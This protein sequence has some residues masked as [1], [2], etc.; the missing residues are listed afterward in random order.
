MKKLHIPVMSLLAGGAL[1][2]VAQTTPAPQPTICT[3][4]CWGARNGTCTT[5]M[6]SLTR[7][8]IHHTAAASNFTTDY[9]AAKT[10]MRNTQNY[11]MD[12]NG[13][14]DVGYHFL[15]SAG[16]HIFEGRKNAMTSLIKGSHA[17]CGNVNSFGF[18]FLG[19]FHPPYNQSPPAAM[20]DGMYDVIAWRMPSGWSPYG[21]RTSYSGSLNGTGAPLDTHQW[22]GAST[23]SGCSSTACPGDVII[24]NFITSNFSGG[25]MR[26]GIAT[27][28]T[29]YINPPYVFNSNA[30]GWTS[31]TGMAGLTWTDCC[32]WTGI[33]YGD[34]TGDDAR[35]YS[36]VTSY[37]GPGAAAI[38]V[39]IHPQN[40]TSANHDM[41][42][43]YKTAAD[44]TWTAGKASPIVNYTAQNSWIRLNLNLNQGAYVGDTIKQLRL[45]FDQVSGGARFIVNHV[46]SQSSLDWQFSANAMGWIAGA[47]VSAISWN[48]S[49]W[50]GVIYCDQTGDDAYIY[51]TAQYFDGASPYKYLGGANDRIHVRIYPQNGGTASHDMQVFWKTTDDPTWTS[52][53]SSAVAY[54]T[55]QNAW[56]DVYLD[57]GAHPLWCSA[58]NGS[59]GITEIRLDFD[60]VNTGVRWIVDYIKFEH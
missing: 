10:A 20:Q 6:S 24:D 41:Q 22:V 33:I 27:R 56:A 23:G 60:A 57:V 5:T 30:Q 49:S 28:R 52:S 38:N 4:S 13:W 8:I 39:S 37:T 26:S 55:A 9:A 18:T 59:G 19:Y 53:K 35:F 1:S 36:P 51:S 7:A 21:G 25:P 58:N 47:R 34:Q 2:V 42:I 16:G 48:G 54:Y 29:P 46:V 40:G 32:G 11:H 3:R 43:F 15:V 12:S 31:G 50:P 14:C 17:G 45:D 44:N